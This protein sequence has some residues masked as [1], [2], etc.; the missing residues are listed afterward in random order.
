MTAPTADEPLILVAD[1]VAAN[2][3]LLADQLQIL[4]FRTV[5]A[6]DGPSALAACFDHRPDLCLLDVSMPAG[7]LGVPDRQTGF[8]VCRRIKRDPRTARIPVIFVTALNDTADRVKAIEAG[9]DDFLTKPHNR[10]VLG[11]RVRSLLKL[12]GATDALE[13]S[14]R[15]L[16][17]L[18]KVR[19]D[20][21][22]MIV[23]DLKSPL[24]SV[25]ATLEMVIDGDFGGVT[26]Q[27][28]GALTDAQ[29]KSQE[30]LAL[31]DDLLQIARIEQNAITLKPQPV[32]PGE[33]LA[34]LLHDWHMRLEAAG[35]RASVEV[36]P[37]APGF[38]ADRALLRRVFSNLL[39]NALV[40]GS[41]AV[42]LRLTARRDPDGVLMTVAD[43]GPGIPPEYHELIF[44]KFETVKL[45]TAPRV[46][47]S[48]LGLAFCKLAVDAHGGRIWV[49][50]VEGQGSQ[51]HIL[52]PLEPVP[53]SRG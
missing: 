34:E 17:E 15:K 25:L 33:F 12:K 39:Q 52:L 21:M 6:S 38:V 30:L 53:P 22:N 50:S 8:E 45:Q 51:F 48:G 4:G 47:G 36:A 3:E 1:D 24:T 16:R 13:D 7:D 18:E 41:G 27:Q 31:I 11:A 37:D 10:L 28:K 23:H 9:G 42:T 20:L 29:D 43:D 46:R 35:A 5:A 44:R 49:Q 26:E 14:L 32:A 40:H 19:D 2:V